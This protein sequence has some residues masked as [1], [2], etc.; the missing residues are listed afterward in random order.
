MRRSTRAVL[1]GVLALSAVGVWAWRLSAPS[2]PAPPTPADLDQLDPEV[3]GRIQLASAQVS[4]AR[5]DAARWV[6]LGKLYEA[7]ELYPAARECYQQALALR[8]VEPRWWYRLAITCVTLGDLDAAIA[9]Y[10]P[11]L[12][13]ARTVFGDRHH[14][15]LYWMA[16]TAALLIDLD[17]FERAESLGMECL[18][19][20]TAVFGPTHQRTLGVHQLRV[21]LY[22]AWNKPGKA[23]EWR[24]K[25]PEPDESDA[26]E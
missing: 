9:L 12:A 16:E 13:D 3:A 21:D 25:L 7:N 11:V 17:N 2:P 8:D 1:A 19:S 24:A 22:E 26:D 23:A 10:E 14:Y 5:T 20:S 15:T 4:A 18:A 6:N